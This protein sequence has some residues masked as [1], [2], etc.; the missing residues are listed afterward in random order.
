M[1]GP[2]WVYVEACWPFCGHVGLCWAYVGPILGPCWAHVRLMLGHVETK[3]GNFADFT[4]VKTNYK[5]TQDS[6]AITNSRLLPLLPHHARQQ[7]KRFVTFG[8]GGFTI[9]CVVQVLVLELGNIACDTEQT[10]SDQCFAFCLTILF[11]PQKF[12]ETKHFM[13]ETRTYVWM[14]LGRL[15]FSMLL[16]RHSSATTDCCFEGTTNL[17]PER[18]IR[19]DFFVFRLPFVYCHI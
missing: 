18:Y 5:K 12:F 6:R 9:A 16:P 10:T 14:R 17:V 3:F 13:P 2:C 7:K 19:R 8:A 4:S 1:L 15:V 11:C